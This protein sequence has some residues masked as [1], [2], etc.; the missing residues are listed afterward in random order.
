MREQ[1]LER[2]ASLYPKPWIIGWN[3]WDGVCQIEANR[4]LAPK[5]WER[6]QWTAATWAALL[7]LVGCAAAPEYRVIQQNCA[8][9][10]VYEKCKAE[11]LEEYPSRQAIGAVES[12]TA[13]RCICKDFDG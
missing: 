8:A 10:N 2:A 3:E 5:R 4:R 13:Y 9:P 7:L 6:K 11:C 12:A 1:A